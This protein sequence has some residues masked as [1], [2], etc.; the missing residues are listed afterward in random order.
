MPDLAPPPMECSPVGHRGG[1]SHLPPRIV[2]RVQSGSRVRIVSGPLAG[3]EGVVA[4]ELDSGRVVI[5]CSRLVQGVL[6]GID[7]TQVESIPAEEIVPG[8][9]SSVTIQAD[10][11]CGY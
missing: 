4:R 2:A 5:A 6:V 11:V 7:P 1:M 9:E 10:D 8:R 3:L